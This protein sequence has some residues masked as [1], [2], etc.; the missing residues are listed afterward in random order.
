MNIL[1]VDYGE[2]NIGLAWCQTGLDV[3]L[4][5]GKISENSKD[6]NFNKLLE[7]I[8]KESIDKLV[9]GYPLSLKGEKNENTISIDKFV[10]QLK[11]V[12]KI[13]IELVDE[14]FSSREADRMDGGVSRD[15]KAAMVILQS[16]LSSRGKK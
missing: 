6:N 12:I 9:I 16:W 1:A 14:R 15:E 2:K 13:E 3:V 11:K 4:P 8:K 7:L 5:Y 10:N